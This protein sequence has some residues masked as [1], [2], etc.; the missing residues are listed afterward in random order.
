MGSCEDL[1][2]KEKEEYEYNKHNGR[3]KR[4]KG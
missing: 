1:I 4:R 3:G 2:A